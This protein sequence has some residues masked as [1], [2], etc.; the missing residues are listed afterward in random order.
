MNL[1]SSPTFSTSNSTPCIVVA[2]SGNGSNFQAIADAIRDEKL[3]AKIACLIVDK[4]CYAIERAHMLGIESILLE[5]PWY[6]HFEE[7]IDR[8]EPALIVLAGFMRIIPSHIVERFFPKIINIHPALLPAFPG[9]D[10]IEQ[11]F[12]YG[13]K[14]VGITIHF[15][16]SGVDTGPI[17]LQKA[18]E[19]K[20]NWNLETL[21]NHIHE[22]EHRYYWQVIDMLLT[23]PFSIE[24]RKFKW[25]DEE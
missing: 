8:I 20:D 25:G 23:R 10:A 13:V 1:S 11:S 16:D 3:H 22:L 24:N 12:E 14:I 6:K 21:E 9:K 19:V 17:I 2:A 7:I 15:V 4:P 18:I 5:R